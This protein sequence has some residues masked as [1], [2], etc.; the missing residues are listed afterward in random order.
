MKKLYILLLFCCSGVLLSSEHGGD[1]A[2]G[3]QREVDQL[4]STSSWRSGRRPVAQPRDRRCFWGM[5]SCTSLVVVVI[6]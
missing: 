3:I 2:R 6:L 1:T 4:S 5:V